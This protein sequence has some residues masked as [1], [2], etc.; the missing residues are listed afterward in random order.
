MLGS[1]KPFV[2]GT[3]F[4]VQFP[5]LSVVPRSVNKLNGLSDAQNDFVVSVPAKGS[6][7][8]ETFIV[9]VS[10]IVIPSQVMS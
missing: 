3:P 6:C 7:S 9:T 5:E 1:M 4:N 2:L 8:N 10:G